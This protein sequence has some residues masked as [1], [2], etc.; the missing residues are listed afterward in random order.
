[1]LNSN[2]G[3]R[4]TNE[5]ADI[6]GRSADEDPSSVTICVAIPDAVMGEAEMPV[7]SHSGRA[8]RVYE[9]CVHGVGFLKIPSNFPKC[10]P[11]MPDT[12][13]SME[14]DPVFLEFPSN[15]SK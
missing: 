12:A 1:M 6:L 14:I 8:G 5:I 10:L 7:G 9:A 11:F 15:V 13:Q 2:W 3:A 4:N